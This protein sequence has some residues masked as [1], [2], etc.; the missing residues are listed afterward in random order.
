MYLYM[1]VCVYVCVC[2]CVARKRAQDT[3]TGLLACGRRERQDQLL[4]EVAKARKAAERDERQRKEV[5][6]C[7][8]THGFVTSACTRMAKSK[9]GSERHE[10]AAEQAEH[11][12]AVWIMHLH[13]RKHY[14]P[15]RKH[16]R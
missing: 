7:D 15:K 11:V 10:R 6:M 2:V 8:L 14:W 16:T 9:T 4:H 3:L 5:C 12:K 13:A 1:C